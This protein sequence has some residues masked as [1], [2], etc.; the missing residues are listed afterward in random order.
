M[1]N[2]CAKFGDTIVHQIREMA[3]SQVIMASFIRTNSHAFLVCFNSIYR[4]NFSMAGSISQAALRATIIGRGNSLLIEISAD[5]VAKLAKVG[6]LGVLAG[7]LGVLYGGYKLLRPIIDVAVERAVGGEQDDQEV[8]FEERFDTHC[9]TDERY[10]EVLEDYESG[11]LEEFSQVRI[12]VE[13]LK[14]EIENMVEVNETKEAV[15]KRYS[16]CLMNM[17]SDLAKSLV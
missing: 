13:G 10:L 15:N 14:V 7:T 11:R 4:M 2:V 3:R 17:L 8:R 1:A 5:S 9:L 6:T 16:R 12:K